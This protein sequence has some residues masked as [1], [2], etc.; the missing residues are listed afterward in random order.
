M[1]RY[2]RYGLNTILLILLCI[3]STVSFAQQREK[4]VHDRGMIHQSVFNTGTIGRPWQ[5]GQAGQSTEDPLSE[6]P[7]YSRTVVDGTEYDG[8]HNMIGAGVYVSANARGRPGLENRLISCCGGLGDHLPILPLGKYSFPISMQEIENFP[9]IPGSDGHGILNPDYN[10][11][12]AE[13]IIIAKWSTSTGIQVTRTSRAWSYPDFDDMIIYEYEFE[14]TGDT[15]GHPQVVERDTTL[16]DVILA[17]TYG[18]APSMFGIQRNYGS[19]EFDA[20]SRGDNKSFFDPDYW[21]GYNMAMRTRA[22][23]VNFERAARPEPNKSFFREWAETGKNGGGLLSPQATGICMLYWDTTHLA[24]VDPDNP[25]RNESEKARYLAEDNAGNLFELDENDH[26]KQPWNW[27]WETNVARPSKMLIRANN[28]NERYGGTWSP[29]YI[30]IYGEPEDKNFVLPDGLDW[31]GRGRTSHTLAFNGAMNNVGFGPYTM[32]IG[33]K[34]ELVMAEVIGYGASEGKWV[35]GGSVGNPWMR[36]PSWNRKIVLDGEVMTEHYLDDYGYPDYINSDVITINEVAHKAFEAYL[37][38]IIPY[39]STRKGPVQ[40]VLW[41]E[42]FKSPKDN[43]DKYKIPVPVPAPV[44]VVK[45]TPSATVK[46]Q[47]NRIAEA[48]Q[49]PRLKGT[50]VKYNLYR[51]NAGL[52]PWS[53]LKSFNV[54][55]VNSEGLY[56][57]EDEDQSWKLGESKYFCVTSVDDEGNES[58][59]SNITNHLKT[60]AAKKTLEKVHAVPNPFVVESGFE[61]IGREKMIGFYGLPKK[62]TIR[63]YSYAGQLVETIEHDE[64]SF[65]EAWFQASRNEQDIA[66]G[67][68]PYIVTTPDGEQTTG[69]LIIIK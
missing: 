54:G 1:G 52:G 32:E 66:S 30:S 40:G 68:Y 27:R 49:H 34:L 45:N 23:D 9:L 14:N 48:F 16:N 39:D 19:W 25:E 28:I 22:Q 37:G 61:G 56:E 43:T 18:Y 21:L 24:I 26:I 42:K 53:L 41:P 6:W 44:I 5:Y 58:G 29:E 31:V 64:D 15:D 20:F 62:C 65:S 2:F 57:Y 10:P 33:D 69:K 63:I 59:K 36:T 12:E 8:Q 3:G 51:S 50:L 7:P 47:W 11:D 55:S 38:K 4:R 46:V 60:V 67:I 17:F 35:L 13:E